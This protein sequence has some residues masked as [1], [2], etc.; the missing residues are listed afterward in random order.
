MK[1]PPPLKIAGLARSRPRGDNFH[2]APALVAIFTRV[3]LRHNGGIGGVSGFGN[4]AWGA[5]IKGE[6]IEYLLKLRASNRDVV[7]PYAKE[8]TVP[9]TADKRPWTTKVADAMMDQGAVKVVSIHY[10]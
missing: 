7:E 3:I 6:K 1:G 5:V 10:H 8:F 9:F 2:R 4:V